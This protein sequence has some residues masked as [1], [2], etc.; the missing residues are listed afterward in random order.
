MSTF[1][2]AWGLH[3]GRRVIG[4]GHYGREL[5]KSC[6]T[7]SNELPYTTEL[8]PSFMT[9]VQSD[10]CFIAVLIL[11]GLYVQHNVFAEVFCC[12]TLHIFSLIASSSVFVYFFALLVD[13]FLGSNC[14][15]NIFL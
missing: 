4:P 8:P 11:G 14:V 2:V 3:L 10:I 12:K 1:E 5:G 15:S 13:I 6:V 9:I 7:A